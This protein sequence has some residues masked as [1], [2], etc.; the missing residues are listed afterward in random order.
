MHLSDESLLTHES[1][2]A[3][4]HLLESN[5]EKSLNNSEHNDI[6][7]KWYHSICLPARKVTEL[8]TQ[9]CSDTSNCMKTYFGKHFC[10]WPYSSQ[11][12]TRLIVL[13]VKDK[14]STILFWGPAAELYQA[15]GVSAIKPRFSII[16][17]IAYEQLN[18]FYR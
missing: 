17:I 6:F 18:V 14:Q 4:R 15:L 12:M 5:L 10:V 16:P 8:A 13:E 1:C 3:R 11:P 7:L 2:E 9:F